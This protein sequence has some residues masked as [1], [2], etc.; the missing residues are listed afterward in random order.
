[1]IWSVVIAFAVGSGT[2]V[3]LLAHG[4][5]SGNKVGKLICKGRIAVKV[6]SV[7]EQTA[8]EQVD[9]KLLR[10]SV[11]V[12]ETEVRDLL[13]RRIRLANDREDRAT[14]FLKPAGSSKSLGGVAGFT[15]H[16]HEGLLV[17][18]I[19]AGEYKLGRQ[20]GAPGN[21]TQLINHRREW[22]KHSL[23]ATARRDENAREAL[24]SNGVSHSLNLGTATIDG[25]PLSENRSLVKRDHFLHGR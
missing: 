3:K 2:S 11:T 5:E 8:Q 23:R 9:D 16:K 10:P 12:D 4:N 14:A 21:V 18:H 6:S 25:F 15:G 22:R 20:N 24:L 7:V 1:M 13:E 19:A 17:H